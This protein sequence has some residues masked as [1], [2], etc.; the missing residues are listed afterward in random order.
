MTFLGMGRQLFG[1]GSRIKLVG[2]PYEML[3]VLLEN[4]GTTVTRKA[5]RMRLWPKGGPVDHYSSPIHRQLR[6]T[7]PVL[8]ISDSSALLF[9][10]T[11]RR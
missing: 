4:P 2:K 3:I 8:S 10:P 9:G 7:M 1:N 6:A 11:T 5:L